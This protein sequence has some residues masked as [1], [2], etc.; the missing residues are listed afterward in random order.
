[1]SAVSAR[2]LYLLSTT[3]PHR[4]KQRGAAATLTKRPRPV[5]QDNTQCMLTPGLIILLRF[6]GPPVPMTARVHST[7]QRPF[8]PV[9]EHSFRSIHRTTPVA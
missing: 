7:P 2:A 1:M 6:T 5:T 8:T 3:I 9:T 4:K